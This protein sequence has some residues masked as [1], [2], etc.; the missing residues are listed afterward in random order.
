MPSPLVAKG[1]LRAKT[2]LQLSR[3]MKV[4]RGAEHLSCEETLRV[5]GLEKAPGR[6]HCG[7]PLLEGSLEAGGRLTFYRGRQ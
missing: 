6:P 5:L 2:Q 4:I 7:L 1:A 3:E